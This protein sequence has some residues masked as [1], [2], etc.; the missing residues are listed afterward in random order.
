VTPDAEQLARE[1]VALCTG[2][3][4]FALAGICEAAPSGRGDEFR[5]WIQSG[6]HGEMTW[7]ARNVEVRLDPRAFVPG[8][9]SLIMVADLYAERGRLRSDERAAKVPSGE[10]R[11]RGRVARYAQGDDY[12][13]VMKKRLHALCDRLRERFPREMFRAFVDTAPVLEREHAA[14]AGLGWIGKHTLLIHP[15][16]GSCMFLGGVATTL[17]IQPAPE[18]R[19]IADHCGTCT[20]CIDACPTGAIS[21]Y[22]IDATR[23][24]SYLTIEHRSSIAPELRPLMGDWLF[25]CDI[26]QEVC[27]HNGPRRDAAAADPTSADL[28][29]DARA[30]ARAHPAYAPRPPAR[31]GFDLLEVLGWS[32]ADRSR[33]LKRSAMKRAKLAMLQR[34]AKA[35]MESSE[36]RAEGE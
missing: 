14:R 34:N 2:E 8:A 33:A 3:F 12:H 35:L 26:C 5:A 19:E 29:G 23:C 15:R 27:P 32:E 36:H 30:S 9:R 11:R 21:P 18:Q 17:A 25:G 7:L 22:S 20:R 1:I 16:L 31:D 6:R 24:I 13:V 4:R 10:G 28:A